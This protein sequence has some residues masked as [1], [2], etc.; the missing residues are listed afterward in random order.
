MNEEETR[1]AVA[2]GI[3]DSINSGA[4]GLFFGVCLF[5]FFMHPL[6]GIALL[7]F[8]GIPWFCIASALSRRRQRKAELEQAARLEARERQ[9]AQWLIDHPPPTEREKDTALRRKLQAEMDDGTITRENIDL[10]CGIKFTQ[11]HYGYPSE[12]A[13]RIAELIEEAKR[14][15]WVGPTWEPQYAPGVAATHWD[16][17]VQAAMDR[18]SDKTTYG[19][20]LL[21]C[22]QVKRDFVA[23]LE[24]GR[25]RLE[26]AR[27]W[28]RYDGPANVRG[29]IAATLRA[30]YG[31]VEGLT[32]KDSAA[33]LSEINGLIDAFGRIE[34]LERERGVAEYLKRDIK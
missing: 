34:K 4:K 13:K 21:W 5:L 14:R 19:S 20:W 23:E 16:T 33:V 32:V 18:S 1:R 2:A 17:K 28:M 15:P 8:V 27:V 26:Q 29:Y 25:E 31:A 10:L 6:A 30:K 12:R 22:E 7:I 24:A 11:D 3:D 9:R